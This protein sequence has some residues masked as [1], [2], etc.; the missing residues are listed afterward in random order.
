MRL[1]F[2]LADSIGL[3][4]TQ[5]VEISLE[6]PSVFGSMARPFGARAEDP[7]YLA[8]QGPEPVPDAVKEAGRQLYDAVVM[9]PELAQYLATALQTQL[10]QRFPIF[11]EIATGS[12]VEALPWETLCTP[13]GNFLGLDERWSIGRIVD[14]PATATP[15][16][17]LSPPLRIAAVLSCLGV[18]AADEWRALMNAVASAPALDVQ[19][20]VVVSE[21]QLYDQI[22][23]E[24]DGGKAPGALVEFV[25]AEPEELQSMVRAFRPHL[26]HFFCHGSAD[27]SPHLQIAV[28][29][30]WVVGAPNDSLL[31]E[32]REIR[33]FTAPTNDPPWAVVL[34]CCESAM[35]GSAQDLQ[36]LALR[37][38]YDGGV[39]A[40][41]G[42]REP[43]LSDDASLFANAFYSRLLGDLAT[44]VTGGTAA[45]DSSV[46]GKDDNGSI[47]WAQLVVSARTKLAK[48][49]KGLT[50][51]QAAA[52][53]KQWTL[54]V[55]YVRPAP[56]AVHLVT[57]PAP[58][59][60]KPVTRGLPTKVQSPH[61][62]RLQIEAWRGLLAQLPPDAPEDLKND[63]E[64]QL[65]E[66]TSQVSHR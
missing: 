63:I 51:S 48:K 30:D 33:D 56:F 60:D 4:N 11:V 21:E 66:L 49:N 3:D 14:G 31:L 52:S 6:E 16:W 39:P 45:A 26:L 9:H 5:H 19:L 61:A 7:V 13:D 35:A 43:V 62:V 44:Y 23:A 8:L 46:G 53:T 42:M 25:P 27:G 57:A 28:K 58:A 55:V 32:A 65:T 36:S 1:V 15:Y 20:L 17:H 54:P 34:N 38:V 24:I 40:V 10:P 37:L 2:Q 50:L 64:A 47:D 18:P 41:V 22:K 29:S 12:G 59:A